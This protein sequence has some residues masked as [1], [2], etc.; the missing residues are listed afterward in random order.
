MPPPSPS[1]AE[2][3]GESRR[4]LYPSLTNPNWLVLRRRREIFEAGLHGLPHSDLSVLD[5]G[6]RLQPYR[7]LLGDRVQRY[8]AVDPQ[9]TSLVNVAAAGEAL[10]FRDEEFDFVIC[11]QVL[12]YFPDPQRAVSEIRRV[13][14]KGGVLFLSAPAVFVQDNANEY[15]RFLPEGLRY[16][17]RDFSAVEVLSEG[18]SLTG[19]FRTLN[20]CMVSFVRPR[21]LA[22]VLQWTL[23]PVSNLV[24]RMLEGLAGTNDLFAANFSVWARK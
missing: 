11:T 8:V 20:V 10:P 17:L 4:R 5:V 18:N 9:I 15:W 3:L 1:L 13:L 7:P 6:G 12:E 24:A 16:I 2:V 21:F 19:M 23:V 14:R 22:P